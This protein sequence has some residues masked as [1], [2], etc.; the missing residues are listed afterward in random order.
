[1]NMSPL[2]MT[3]RMNQL[4][5]EGARVMHVNSDFLKLGL[6]SPAITSSMV[7][8]YVTEIGETSM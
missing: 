8:R 5:D 3:N 4:L 1:M 2:Q 7:A 6:V